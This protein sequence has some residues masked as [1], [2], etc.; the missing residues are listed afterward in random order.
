MLWKTLKAMVT[1]AV[2]VFSTGALVGV[3]TMENPAIIVS[4]LSSSRQSQKRQWLLFR[5]RMHGRWLK[6]TKAN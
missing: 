1:L 3:A 4:G 2:F 6:W 5:T